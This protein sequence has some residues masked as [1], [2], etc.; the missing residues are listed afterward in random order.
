MRYPTTSYLKK[1]TYESDLLEFTKRS[2]NSWQE[3]R[4][5]WRSLYGDNYDDVASAKG[6]DFDIV[7]H[8][9]LIK[10]YDHPARLA[11][12]YTNTAL[13]IVS[14]RFGFENLDNPTFK[15]FKNLLATSKNQLKVL[16]HG[17]KD[18]SHSWPFW[19]QGYHVTMADLPLEYLKFIKWRVKKHNVPDIDVIFIEKELN[20]LGDKMFDLL[21]SREVMEHCI[22]Y[23]KLLA[24]LSDH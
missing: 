17:C 14:S 15:F 11:E 24:Y 10:C 8:D 19:N 1:E 12:V 6:Y 20:Y 7:T 2:F 4:L 21:W 23:H 18:G 22:N 5:K 9:G 16:D 3:E 13:W